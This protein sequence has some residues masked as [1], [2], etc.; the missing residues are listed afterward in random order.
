MRFV[1]MF[2]YVSSASLL[3]CFV[4][5][6]RRRDIFVICRLFCRL[7]V[8]WWV[9]LESMLW[10]FFV[11]SFVFHLNVDAFVMAADDFRRC[12]LPVVYNESVIYGSSYEQYVSL[13]NR[14]G[15]EFVFYDLCKHFGYLAQY[16]W[17]VSGSPSD[18]NLSFVW[19][20]FY[21][22]VIFISGRSFVR[23]LSVVVP[24]FTF[25]FDGV[26]FFVYQFVWIRV[27][28][29]CVIETKTA[30]L[31]RHSSW[32]KETRHEVTDTF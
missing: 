31:L 22:E 15:S 4:R 17:C 20:W 12:G 11:L 13:A 29:K 24:S 5:L 7:F 10:C 1:M 18:S 8:C 27:M 3:G 19:K 23:A 26:Y 21:W 28:D 2:F 16:R 9:G 25:S 14:G 32:K 6:W 30:L